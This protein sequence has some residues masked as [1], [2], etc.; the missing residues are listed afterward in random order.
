[1]KR[2][3]GISASSGIAVGK[4]FLIGREEFSVV[5]KKISLEDIPSEILR[6]EDALIKTR[7]EL[8]E[9][10]KEIEKNL[11]SEHAQIFDA[12]LLVLEDRVL[13]EDVISKIKKN[14]INVEY[15]F[16]EVIKKYI[17]TLSKLDDGYLKERALDL[18]DVGKRVLKKLLK[19][20]VHSYT[21]I[22]EKVIIVAHDLSPADTVSL[23]KKKILGFATDIGGRTS[24][25]AIIARALGIPAVVGLEKIT[26]IVKPQDL[27]VI[28]GTKGEVIV[29]PPEEVLAEY[30]EKQEE[31]K[32][33]KRFFYSLK[34]LPAQT[35]D[36]KR[37]VLAAN[38]ELPEEIPLVLEW[39]A[40]GVGLYR[41]EFIYL[42]RKDLPS[43]EEQYQAYLNV[44][45]KVKPY[46]V[47]IRTLDLGGDKF[48]SQP[49]MP[50]EMSPFLG[51]RAIRFCLA[52]PQIFKVQLRAILRASREGN[53]KLMFPMISG[54]EELRQARKLLEEVKEELRREGEPFD[55]NI[56]VGVMIEVPSAALMSDV[57]A[58]E[59]DFFSIGTNDLIQYSLAVDRANE[60]VAYLYEPTHPG[61]LRL[62]R[63]IIDNAHKAGIWV[64]MCG[65]MASEPLCA[66][67]LLGMD[68]DELSVPPSSIPKVK[69]LIRSVKFAQAS[70]IV[71]K[72]INLSTHK[73]VE[74]IA[75]KF[76]KE[77]L[78]EE[79]DKIIKL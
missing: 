21:Q 79:F 45:K 22:K 18:R 65:E 68:I 11:G 3:K 34:K 66:F 42:G 64:G 15:A 69:K 53:L 8:I 76:L 1:M 44:A 61:V 4:A 33:V 20:D 54:I 10:Q 43:E 46:P 41:T 73:E 32:Q 74:R 25:T 56:E 39:G 24:H 51:W 16:W 52:Q 5:C 2:I 31:E 75:T 7:R 38:I 78:R 60:K 12:H 57:L 14:R 27:I 62:L 58:K 67:L 30:K 36:N 63:I 49:L 70:Q 9:F 72:V 37:I 40:E 13:I 55:E 17:E 48:L 26:F 29:N 23:P 6:L 35:S 59:A 71:E 28:D 19:K 50:E 77:V 47:V